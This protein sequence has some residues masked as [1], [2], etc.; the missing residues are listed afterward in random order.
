MSQAI[1]ALALAADFQIAPAQ[2][3]LCTTVREHKSPA[4][5]NSTLQELLPALR[6]QKGT[7][8]FDPPFAQLLE[9]L[10]KSPSPALQKILDELK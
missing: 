9:T 3:L 8:A 7:V 2:E 4:V 1:K 6:A 10:R 5:R